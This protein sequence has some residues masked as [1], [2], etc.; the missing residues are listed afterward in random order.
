MGAVA[1]RVTRVV[2]LPVRAV[3]EPADVTVIDAFRPAWRLATDLANWAQLQLVTRDV[4]RTPG[5]DR[6]PAYDR[7]AVFGTVPR[8]FARK[9]VGD[10]PACAVGEPQASSL[11]DLW[12]RECPFRAAFDGATVVARDVLRAVED[13]WRKHK[14]FGRLAVL[15]KGEARPCVFRFPYPWPVAADKGRTLRLWRD[16]EGRP[17]AS[18]PNPAG[19]GRIAV[20]LA[21]G[22]EFR[23]QLRQFDALLADP[24]RLRQ[25]KVT[26][27]RVAG[28]LAGA[29]L[30]VVGAFDRAADAAGVTA[31]VRTGA[32]CVF[33]ATTAEDDEP[34]VIHADQLRGA[35]HC[36]DR[37]RHRF[38]R[39]LKYEKRWPAAKRRRTVDGPT[40]K[41]RMERMHGR[42]AAERGQLVSCLV[43]WLRRNGVGDVEYDDSET[44]YFDWTDD[45]GQTRRRFD[46]TALREAVRCKCEDAGIGFQHTAGADDG[47]E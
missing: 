25:G 14:S 37:W 36:Y 38:A 4:R 6:L 44:G 13:A 5:M 12:N 42:I 23:R 8:R 16:A 29:D 34:F 21:D 19:G 26:G 17:A 7:A 24:G 27:R 35:I 40:A 47:D 43:G 9:A 2:T 41:S 20:R 45:R 15:W 22:R 3:V 46:L 32:D 33:R 28:R 10:K 39:D 1:D 31:V 11:Y 18:I 30:R